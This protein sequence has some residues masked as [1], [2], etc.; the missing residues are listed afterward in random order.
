MKNK[1]VIINGLAF[2]ENS[3]MEMLSSYAKKGWIL[4]GISGAIFYR[5][6]KDKPQDIKYSLD[7]QTES[8]KEY[9]DLFL[10]AGWTPVVSIANKMHI[11]SAPAGTKPIYTECVSEVDKY[12][13]IKNQTKKASIYFFIAA[14][15][16]AV[17][18]KISDVFIRPLFPIIL[19]LLIASTVLFVPSLITYL[20]LEHRIKKL[21]Q[22]RKNESDV[23][24]VAVGEKIWV[25]YGIV[26][27]C[28]ICVGIKCLTEKMRVFGVLAMVFGIVIAI[29]IILH[30]REKKI[31]K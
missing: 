15:I 4:E 6:R 31:L 19:I 26:G 3:D 13:K 25:L 28:S 2:S 17:L 11:F 18:L 23:A 9:F 10:E 22:N 1:Y 30:Y 14:I 29:L 16:F 20:G 7:Y 21:K 24:F 8:T 5:L 12:S 27:I